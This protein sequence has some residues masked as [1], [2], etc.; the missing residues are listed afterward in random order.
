[1][2]EPST[3]TRSVGRFLGGALMG[4][5]L[6]W[7]WWRLSQQA[8]HPTNR[9]PLIQLVLRHFQ[10]MGLV[11]VYAHHQC[12][13][14]CF[15]SEGEQHVVQ[16]LRLKKHP[17]VRRR[18]SRRV[19]WAPSQASSFQGVGP[20]N[21][22]CESCSQHV[23]C[24]IDLYR[25]CWDRRCKWPSLFSGVFGGRDPH[26]YVSPIVVHCRRW[27]DDWQETVGMPSYPKLRKT[28]S[29]VFM[30]LW[31]KTQVLGSEHPKNLL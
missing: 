15:F 22:D 25:I 16:V 26:W 8:I 5:L 6:M 19:T 31:V 20:E 14:G 9:L 27:L 7:F 4:V 24:W 2:R 3:S 28:I 17:D 30:L 23:L 10:R 21:N 1:M 18:R 29:V 12:R 11:H 13:E